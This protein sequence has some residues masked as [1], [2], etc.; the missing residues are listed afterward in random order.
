MA[1]LARCPWSLLKNLQQHSKVKS[2]R[3][4]LLLLFLEANPFTNFH[5]VA[6]ADRKWLITTRKLLGDNAEEALGASDQQLVENM[7]KQVYENLHPAVSVE[8]TPEMQAEL[9]VIFTKAQAFYR[10]VFC[11]DSKFEIRMAKAMAD[12]K[13][14]PFRP[15][16]MEVVN[17]GADDETTLAG[18]P[19]EISVFPGVIKTQG[20]SHA[21]V[22]DGS[23][24]STTI[25]QALTSVSR[26]AKVPLC[27][28]PK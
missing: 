16:A 18:K 20:G 4:L 26:E 15:E 19:I 7:A 10:L 5:N 28:K 24:S 22:S 9:A 27:P 11:Q 17:G 13:F 23:V 1:D 6:N 3:H 14:R 21:K 12:H 25:Q 8:W 2:L